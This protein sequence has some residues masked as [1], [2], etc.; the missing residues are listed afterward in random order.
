MSTPPE[1]PRISLVT[2]SYNQGEFIRQTIESVLSQQYP[3]LD[4]RVVDGGSTDGTLDILREYGPRLQWV[5]EPDRGQ[6]H[7]L[8]KGLSQATGDV[9]GFIN[10]DD[11]LEP[12]ALHRVGSFFR[13]HP[14]AFWVTGRCR[15][16]DEAGREMRR[17]V[18][19]Y[20]NFW[21]RGGS[22][23]VLK[24]LNYVSQPAT[25]WRRELHEKVGLFAED[26]RF[27][28]DYDYWLRAS[29]HYRLWTLPEY[30]ACFRLHCRSKAGAIPRQ[31][32][33][34]DLEIARKHVGPGLLLTV[35]A[36]HNRLIIAANRILMAGMNR[37][38]R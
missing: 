11:Y 31:Q 20:K 9:L 36:F 30:L 26:L 17:I 32:F 34:A 38:S 3:N 8:N 33:D 35:H 23:T 25:F 10:S 4:Y 21:L 6:S 29:Q 37:G 18:T 2:P 12:D 14:E 5:S 15:T 7:A 19:H 1:L 22:P 24:C 16:V 27:A 28:M 13:E